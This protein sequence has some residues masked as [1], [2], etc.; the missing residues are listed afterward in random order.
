MFT[1][2]TQFLGFSL[3]GWTDCYTFDFSVSE[4]EAIS[5]VA[6]CLGV[7]IGGRAYDG[8]YVFQRG[9]RF[10]TW[11]SFG[12]ERWPYQ[13]ISVRLEDK[14]LVLTYHII[15]GVWLRGKPC[16]LEKEARGIASKIQL[17]EQDVAGNSDHSQVR[18]QNHQ[19]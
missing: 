1:I 6:K 15:G 3:S 4:K 11:C 18:G 2:Q 8:S 17:S 5:T 7:E 14:L 16:G 13:E 10:W 12:T 19:D 9:S